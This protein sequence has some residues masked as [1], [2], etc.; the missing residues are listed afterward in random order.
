M[1]WYSMAF[2]FSFILRKISPMTN[3]I[4]SDWKK[5]VGWAGLPVLHCLIYPIEGFPFFFSVP[6]SIALGLIVI[7]EG[8][9]THILGKKHCAQ[10]CHRDC[11]TLRLARGFSPVR[12][13]VWLDY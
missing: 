7:L 2:P 6:N 13:C 8:K 1:A 12:R 11:M 4:A 10:A 5:E 9:Y 3:S